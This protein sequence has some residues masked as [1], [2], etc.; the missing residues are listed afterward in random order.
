MH[1]CYPFEIEDFIGQTARYI[2]RFNPELTIVKPSTVCG[3]KRRAPSPS[4]SGA[5]VVH[6]PVRGK[7]RAD[8]RGAPAL[9]KVRGGRSIRPPAKSAATH[10]ESLGMRTSILSSPEATE[11]AKLTETTYFG[12]IIAWAQEA[13]RYCDRLGQEYDEIASFWDEVKFLPVP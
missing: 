13:E 1:V 10:F 6:S 9:R 12:L 11:L 5:A 7:A 8:A 2:A 4:G 3:R